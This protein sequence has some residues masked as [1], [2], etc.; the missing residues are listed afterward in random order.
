M[1][2]QGKALEVRAET[3]S[4]AIV[5]LLYAVGL[6]ALGACGGAPA[7]PQAI[8]SPLI[9]DETSSGGAACPAGTAADDGNP[10][11]ADQCSADGSVTHTPMADFTPCDDGNLC[12]LGE[13]CQAGVC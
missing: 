4:S 3:A 5:R 2:R 7:A 9:A 11:T 10:C 13:S 12:T 1:S 6:T 8:R